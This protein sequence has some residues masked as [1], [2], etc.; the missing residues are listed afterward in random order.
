MNFQYYRIVVTNPALTI[1]LS[2]KLDRACVFTETG[3][4]CVKLYMGS[5]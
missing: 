5:S 2:R 4:K 1:A 3:V